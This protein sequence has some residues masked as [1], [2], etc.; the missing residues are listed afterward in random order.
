MWSFSTGAAARSFVRKLIARNSPEP[1][2][3]RKRAAANSHRL[4]QRKESRD[5]TILL[6]DLGF[7]GKALTLFAAI[8]LTL[9]MT[10]Q[11]AA[12]TG[13]SLH[14]CSYLTEA[15]ISAAVGKVGAH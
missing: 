9:I 1:Y 13:S 15:Q 10:P 7:T 14:P 11:A 12:E 6:R 5:M 8:G 4:W 2:L 3:T